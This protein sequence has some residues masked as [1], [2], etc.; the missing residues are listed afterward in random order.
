MVVSTVTTKQAIQNLRDSR[1][2]HLTLGRT[3][4]SAANAAMFPMD[5]FS[6]AVL[7]RS[8]CLTEAFCDLLEKKNFVVAASLLRLQLDNLIRFQAAWLVDKPH[9]FAT[10]VLSGQKISELKDRNGKFMKDFYLVE[11]LSEK[12]P[13]MKEVYRQTSGYIHLSEKH[14]FN[15]LG[16]SKKDLKEPFTM[17]ISSTDEFVTDKDYLETLAAFTAITGILFQYAKGWE[18]AKDQTFKMHNP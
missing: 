16:K 3:I 15:S 1:E 9:E 11:K 7:N 10:S 4:I 18:V 2:I 12:Y 14:I 17:K 8:L 5:I 13:Q 6:I